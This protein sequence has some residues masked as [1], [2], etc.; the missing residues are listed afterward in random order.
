MNWL[1]P[2][3]EWLEWIWPCAKTDTW[4]K[5]VRFTYIPSMKIP[6]FTHENFE[7]TIGWRVL[8]ESRVIVSELGPGMHRKIPYFEELENH[9]VV[10]DPLHVDVQNLTMADG[11]TITMKLGII[12]EIFNVVKVH[13]E[14]H[15]YE[16]AASTLAI[17][18]ASRI[19]RVQ[20]YE[21]CDQNAME[22]GIKTS[23][24]EDTKKWG[25][26]IKEVGFTTFVKSEQF[27]RFQINQNEPQN[28]AVSS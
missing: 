12:Y 14:V 18:H 25:M 3:K 24:H 11:T 17:I 21:G 13:T 22:E 8:W 1:Q 26:R 19:V 28:H 4:Q 16:S 20:K 15:N 6:W 23:L 9:S 2:I 10:P 5:A 27:N 7:W